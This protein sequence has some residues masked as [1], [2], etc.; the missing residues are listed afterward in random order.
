MLCIAAITFIVVFAR[1]DA[2][3][4][5]T[6]TAAIFFISL[7]MLSMTSLRGWYITGHDIQ[8]EYKVF[9]LTKSNGDWNISNFQDAY[10]A[11]LSL[12]ILPTTLWQLM[13]VDD[14]YIY[15]FWFQL[16]FA[17]CP[18]FVYRISLRYTSPGLAI[19]AVIYFISFPTFFTDMPF[20]NRQEM[21][22]LFVA[23]IVTMATAPKV[24][25]KSVRIP[26]SVF[27][28]GVVLSHYSTSYVFLGTI[29]LGYVVHKLL[30]RLRRRRVNELEV[31]QAPTREKAPYDPNP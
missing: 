5:G 12:T 26:I 19:I 24:P 14:P 8:G 17:L 29:G 6:I 18:V 25:P 10:N 4:P 27:S 3:S 20:L 16:L 22:Y 31:G 13:R 7:A 30:A 21:A 2:L 1:Q 9:E 15:K 28:V 23:A 11:C